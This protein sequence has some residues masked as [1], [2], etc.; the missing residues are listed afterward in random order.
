MKH[1][2]SMYASVSLT[3]GCK[4]D[5]EHA[6]AGDGEDDE[7]AA[8]LKKQGWSTVREQAPSH[9]IHTTRYTPKRYKCGVST[10]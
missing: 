4:V 2:T 10:I 8:L 1:D 7:D 9:H 6:R 3:Y 5:D